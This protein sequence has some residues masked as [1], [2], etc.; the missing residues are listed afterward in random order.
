MD[1]YIAQN[2]EDIVPIVAKYGIAIL[3]NV[4]NEEEC[5]TVFSQAWDFF[6]ELYPVLKRDDPQTW[7]NI[8]DLKPLHGMLFQ[9]WG[10]GHA[11]YIWNLRTNPKIINIYKTI[12][13]NILSQNEVDEP[14]NGSMKVSFDGASFGVPPENTNRGWNGKDWFHVD[15]RFIDGS[16]L[17]YNT[18]KHNEEEQI[19]HAEKLRQYEELSQEEKVNREVYSNMQ[20]IQSWVT[21][22]DVGPNDAT[23]SVLEGSNRLHSELGPRIYA[24]LDSKSKDKLYKE[25]WY[26]FSQDELSLYRD[27]PRVNVVCKAGSMVFWD[28]RTVHCGRGPTKGRDEPKFRNV[29]YLCYMPTFMIPYKIKDKRRKAYNELRTT[30]HW[31]NKAKLFS[32]MPR[33][34]GA[35]SI[36]P[37]LREYKKIRPNINDIGNSLI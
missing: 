18:Y 33:I 25:D 10:I 3:E 5:K 30:S 16:M 15:Q 17:Y 29:I 7:K 4:L 13:S 19:T 22:E 20:C 24:G 37:E 1:K 11:Q 23:L 21:S 12:W 35:D 9:H 2:A 14:F 32:K 26:K 28:S 34:Y 31:P 6:E 8:H 27:C 36:K